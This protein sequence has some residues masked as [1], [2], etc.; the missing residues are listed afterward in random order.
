MFIEIA[1]LLIEIL[2]VKGQLS[3]KAGNK[4]RPCLELLAQSQG[5]PSE[6][7]ISG[8]KRSAAPLIQNRLPVV[9][10]GP[11]SKRCPR[12]PPQFE[13]FTSRPN[14][15]ASG[16]LNNPPSSILM[17]SLDP[18]QKEGQPVPES[19]L[20]SDGKSGSRHPAQTKVP[21]RFSV[22]SSDE[23]AGSVPPRNTSRARTDTG[24]S[25]ASDE[26]D[27]GSDVA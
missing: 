14:T 26:S 4:T 10:R 27:N 21:A 11:S 15:V 18:A 5:V 24:D 16:L 7:V 13:H 22:S 12:C 19:N 17:A 2:L 23:K 20:H 3:M 9:F 6:A 1:L 25:A 8:R